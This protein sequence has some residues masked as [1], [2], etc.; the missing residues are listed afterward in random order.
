MATTRDARHRETDEDAARLVARL[1]LVVVTVAA[2]AAG[3]AYGDA[4]EPGLQYT[5][6]FVA[7]PSSVALALAADRLPPTMAAVL[8]AAI[9]L[10]VFGVAMV[11][12][13]DGVGALGAAFLV[14]VLLASYTGGRLLG[15][16]LGVAGVTLIGLADATE[17]VTPAS[18]TMLLLA[19]AIAVC[20]AVVGRADARLLRSTTRARYHEARATLIVDHLAEAIVVTG[21]GGR[22]RQYNAAADRLLAPAAGPGTCDAMLDL[23]VG[24]RRLDCATGCALLRLEAGDPGGIEAVACSGSDR[25]VPVMVSVA[26][27]PGADG[28]VA[29][30]LHT[31]RDITKLKQADEAKTLFLATATHE[32]K[33][34]VTVIAGFLKTIATPGVSDE[35]RTTAIDV[36]R[37]RADELSGII[38]RILLASRIES[39]RLTVDVIP[40]DVAQVAGE[41]VDALASSSGRAISL[42]TADS[43]P[44]ALAEDTALATVLDH[45][46][47]NACKYSPPDT[48]VRVSVDVDD[49]HVVLVVRD[50]GYGMTAEEAARCFDR[51]W[52][53]DSS[54]RRQAGGTGIGLYIVRSLVES[55]GGSITVESAVGEGTAFT[56][57]LPRADV[58]P[59]TPDTGGAEAPPPQPSIVREFMRQIGVRTEESIQ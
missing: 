43:L 7:V 2:L 49:D 13:P 51:F 46:I 23:R 42:T 52:Q 12:F 32:L 15:A 29:E 31:L 26:E 3:I 37:R 24:G 59:S 25:P 54:S 18:D 30:H 48:P 33:T 6:T 34:P 8:G 53:A 36:M 17:R 19:I 21:P 38:E 58:R 20:L 11:T 47:D 55:I 40:T 56:V 4:G 10:V 16:G 39:G 44:A 28:E 57:R 41:R 27:I 9:D 35:M 45:V 5:L 22:I 14:P 50:V 1:R